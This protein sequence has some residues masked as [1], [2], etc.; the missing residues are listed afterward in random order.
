[1][2]PFLASPERSARSWPLVSAVPIVQPTMSAAGSPSL[3]LI[4]ASVNPPA[5]EPS[6]ETVTVV[7]TGTSLWFG[8]QSVL[9]LAR[10]E[11]QAG[12]APMTETITDDGSLVRRPSLVISSNTSWPGVAGAVN[13]GAAA[14]LFDSVTSVP[15]VWRQ[16]KAM[17]SPSGSAPLPWS[18]TRL[19][20]GTVCGSPAAAVGA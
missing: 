5:P 11:S 16:T 7:C 12:P 9:G 3:W 20:T 17:A 15:A 18:V 4:A 19:F 13:A 10:A 14:W 8:G 1:V 6:S 2:R